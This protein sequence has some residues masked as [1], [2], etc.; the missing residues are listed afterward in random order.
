M[1]NS[2]KVI[3]I[4]M[5]SLFVSGLYANI[6]TDSFQ[7][8]PIKRLVPKHVHGDREFGGNGPDVKASVK[9][10]ILSTDKTKIN[11]RIYLNAK[12][13][14][15]NWTEAT[16]SWARTIMKAPSG[17]EFVEILSDKRSEAAYRDHNH[18]IDR[19]QVMGGNLVRTF[20]IMGDTPG[21]DVGNNTSDDVFMN[22]YFNKV[23][24]TL[25]KV[26]HSNILTGS[27]TMQQKHVR[28]Y[29]D[30][31]ESKNNDFSVVTRTSQ[32][33]DTQKW[34]FK[35]L[36]NGIYTIQQ[37]SSGRFLDAYDY[38]GT[39]YNVV[40][41]TNQANN[42]QRWRVKKIGTNTY[43]LQQV[44]TGRY[45]DA[46]DTQN[47]DFSVVTRTAQKNDTQRWIIQR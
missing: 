9:I 24:Y 13:T 22:I 29:L 47:R 11:A 1:K 8:A 6:Y 18:D 25:R 19:P 12:E 34:T 43:T 39:D 15:A 7:P 14:R 38:D 31:H 21:N 40:T 30:A 4:L 27:Y 23:K 2:M 20:E 44:N 26:A 3:S 10:Y 41:R 28:R 42:T 36:G 45:L 33:N 17:Y 5:F 35:H 37:R 46:H 32:S 16:G